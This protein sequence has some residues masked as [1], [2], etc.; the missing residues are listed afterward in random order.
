MS[1]SVNSLQT[2]PALLDPN[3]KEATVKSLDQKHDIS[4]Q[5]QEQ[6][7]SKIAFC[8]ANVFTSIVAI[9]AGLYAA[10]YSLSQR[11]YKPYFD[12]GIVL[13]SLLSGAF[14][15]LNLEGKGIEIR[16]YR[17][18][19]KNTVRKIGNTALITTALH[20]FSPIAPIASFFCGINAGA[21]ISIL[22]YPY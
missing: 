15:G 7:V 11:S 12:S 9:A 18:L 19:M 21:A 22:T 13:G 8:T 2:T 14:L 16:N 3:H 10:H 5:Q 17:E 6:R 4:A 20:T 1:V